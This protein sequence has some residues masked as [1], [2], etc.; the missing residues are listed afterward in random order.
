MAKST[1]MKQDTLMLYLEQQKPI[2]LVSSHVET[3]MIESTV[4]L[5]QQQEQVLWQRWMQ[6]AI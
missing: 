1:P 5:L 3:F 2:F 6:N 4:K